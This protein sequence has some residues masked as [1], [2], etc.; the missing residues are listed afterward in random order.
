MHPTCLRY[1]V[2]ES[3]CTET[4]PFVYYRD[5][6]NNPFSSDQKGSNALTF[7][8]GEMV[9]NP[10]QKLVAAVLVFL[11]RLS[12]LLL[13]LCIPFTLCV[14][15]TCLLGNGA[16]KMISDGFRAHSSL[17]TVLWGVGITVIY[18]LRT[19]AL[20][21]GLNVYT[22]SSL[23]LMQISAFSCFTT[24][25][26]DEIGDFNHV[27]AAAAWIVSTLL[28]HFSCTLRLGEGWVYRSF[29]MTAFWLA[30]LC[31][32]TFL[33]LFIFVVVEVGGLHESIDV[34]TVLAVL[35]LTVVYLLF[36]LDLCI[37]S[38]VL[39]IVLKHQGIWEIVRDDGP[40]IILVMFSWA[41]GFGVVLLYFFLYT[42]STLIQ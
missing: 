3:Y 23:I 17:S 20:E 39:D 21:Q 30:S 4:A 40:R 5:G 1:S 26:Y 7:S 16:L 27:I 11:A 34:L 22:T 32:A 42:D 29:T 38:Y 18:S 33:T 2:P 6:E 10:T 24:L 9:L 8:M 37:S 31:G 13:M 36:V 12:I 41:L 28:F 14:P 25:R 15:N 19:V 35:E